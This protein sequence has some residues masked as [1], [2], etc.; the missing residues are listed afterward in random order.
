MSFLPPY[1]SPQL[2]HN[3]TLDWL[4]KESMTDSRKGDQCVLWEN[5]SR[6]IVEDLSTV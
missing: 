4:E 5:F 6:V 2:D 3:Y 1:N